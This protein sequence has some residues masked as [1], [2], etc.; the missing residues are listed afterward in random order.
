MAD[1]NPDAYLAKKS[2]KTAGFDPDA[3]LAKRSA[4]DMSLPI[5]NDM[6]EG[7]GLERLN[8]KN[9]GNDINSSIE[10]LKAQKP[11]YDFAEKDGEILIKKPGDKAW[12]RLDPQGFDLQD[13]TDLGSDVVSGVGTTAATI[14]GGLAGGGVGAIPAGIA[15]SGGI[16]ALRQYLGTKTGVNKDV[17]GT[18]VAVAGALGGLSPFLFGSGASA[19]Q[20]AKTAAAKGLPT[21]VV[22]E[23]QRGALKYL[24]KA[25][26]AFTGVPKDTIKNAGKAAPEFLKDAL[27]LPGNATNLDAANA[28]ANSGVTGVVETAIDDVTSKLWSAKSEL[29]NEIGQALDSTGTVISTD[30]Y[31]KPFV[32]AIDKLSKLKQTEQVKSQIAALQQEAENLF[33]VQAPGGNGP[34]QTLDLISGNQAMNLKQAFKDLTDTFASQEGKSPAQKEVMRAAQS[35]YHNISKDINSTI[36]KVGS[37]DLM[38]KYA[39]HMEIERNILPIFNSDNPGK[40]FNTLR[41]L[42]GKSKQVLKEGLGKVDKKYG[43]NVKSTAD[44]LDVWSHLGDPGAI[45]TSGGA[46]TSTSRTTAARALGTA[47]G[48]A[49]GFSMF[50]G[51]GAVAGGL[52]GNAASGVAF[53]PATVKMG[54][55]LQ[56]AAMKSPVGGL[57]RGVANTPYTTQAPVA[58]WKLLEGNK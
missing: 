50:G 42:N 57:V 49:A 51:P 40:A 4:P 18:D 11:G 9:L 46:A 13:I 17:K 35:A 8:I 29:Q 48:T 39:D 31:K 43:T 2:Q 53:S 55:G 12:G 58:A 10:Y 26:E 22:K 44:M 32:D 56:Q 16:E 33:V 27:G 6:P 41:N 20:I 38:S 1:F 30:K 36:S 15:S 23:A 19:G 5:T 54:L 21:E 37:K 47:I 14:A 34:A 52:L 28:V 25:T 7:F 45:A 3:Y 24:P